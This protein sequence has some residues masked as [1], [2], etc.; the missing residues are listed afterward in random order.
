MVQEELII[1]DIINMMIMM[2]T[3]LLQKIY[4]DNFLTK[5]DSIKEDNNSNNN[6]R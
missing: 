2:M 3:F 4:L 1:K 6:H 5:E